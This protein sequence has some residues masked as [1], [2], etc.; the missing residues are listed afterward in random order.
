MDD[1]QEKIAVSVTYGLVQA[2]ADPYE[3]R[4]ALAE[5]WWAPPAPSENNM[6]L[7]SDEGGGVKHRQF[8][9]MSLCLHIDPQSIAEAAHGVERL[10]LLFAE[11]SARP[12][13]MDLERD[14]FTA[15]GTF[16]GQTVV[17][18]RARGN[19]EVLEW[20]T[21]DYQL[22]ASFAKIANRLVRYVAGI[23]QRATR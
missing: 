19:A 23:H 20:Q 11:E 2:P 16:S 15:E 22:S 8:L 13:P 7:Q 12:T 9:G 4:W 10:N 17:I 5:C 14:R 6:V 18:D 3:N 21:G 1:E